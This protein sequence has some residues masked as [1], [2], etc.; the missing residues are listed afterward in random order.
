MGITIEQT[1]YEPIPTGKY[2]AVI[3]S[4]EATDGKFGSQLKFK[5]QLVG[6]NNSQPASLLGWA[7]AKFSSRSKLYEWTKAAFGGKPIPADYLFDSDDLIGKHVVLTVVED[8]G[9]KGPFNRID[10]VKPYVKTS[11]PQPIQDEPP[12]PEAPPDMDYP[13]HAAIEY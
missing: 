1:K 11:K 10:S 3:D 6:D 13:G 7:S 9:E 4:I 5:F 8:E 12:E 2:L